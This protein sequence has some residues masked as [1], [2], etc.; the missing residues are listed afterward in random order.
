MKIILLVCILFAC[1]STLE[2]HQDF[3]DNADTN[4]EEEKPDVGG[5]LNRP[6]G[7][8]YSSPMFYSLFTREII[9]GIPV[10]TWKITDLNVTERD[11]ICNEQQ[12]FCSVMNYSVVLLLSLY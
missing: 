9:V 3:V 1:V 10:G 5:S 6:Y 7:K 4:Q 11:V 2:T 8:H 12:A